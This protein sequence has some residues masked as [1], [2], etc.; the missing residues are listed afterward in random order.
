VDPT[1][2]GEIKSLVLDGK[3]YIKML[4]GQKSYMTG[5]QIMGK[6]NSLALKEVL[7]D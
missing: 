5:R 7:R 3:H 4:M 2:K 6:A 1:A